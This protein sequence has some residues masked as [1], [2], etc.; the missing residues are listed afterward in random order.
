MPGGLGADPVFRAKLAAC[1]VA[2][3]LHRDHGICVHY[4]LAGTNP[5]VVGPPLVA[6]PEHVERFL[7]GFEATLAKGLPRLLATF[8]SEKVT[9][10]W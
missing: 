7:D 8:L 5:L 4:D 1:A 9:T 10:L 3:A 6:Q 2:G